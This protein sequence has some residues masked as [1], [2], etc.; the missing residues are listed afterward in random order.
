MKL[1]NDVVKQDNV[2]HQLRWSKKQS[3][4]GNMQA[5]SIKKKRKKGDKAGKQYAGKKC[6]IVQ[7]DAAN[8]IILL[9]QW[10]PPSPENKDATASCYQNR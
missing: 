6:V 5:R 7:R 4:I 9:Y 1:G 2:D 10:G 3:W 8:V